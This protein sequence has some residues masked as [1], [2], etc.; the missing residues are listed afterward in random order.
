[1]SKTE[2]ILLRLFTMCGYRRS[3]AAT[4]VGVRNKQAYTETVRLYIFNFGFFV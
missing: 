3:F 4:F 1:M 2:Y